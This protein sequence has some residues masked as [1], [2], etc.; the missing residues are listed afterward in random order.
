MEV[1][2]FGLGIGVA[3]LA[4]GVVGRS[5]ARR[6]GLDPDA[7]WRL[8]AGLMISGAIGGRLFYVLPNAGYYLKYPLEII[9]PPVEG[10]SYYGALLAGAAYARR[11]ARRAELT[12]GQVADLVALPWLVGLLLASLFWGAPTVKAGSPYGVRLGLDILYLTGLYALLAWAWNA[13]RLCGRGKLALAVLA[14]DSLL[15]LVTGLVFSAFLPPVI[16]WP[17][18][19]HLARA[20]A[21]LAGVAMLRRLR[22]VEPEPPAEPVKGPV[23]GSYSRWAG[24]LLVYGVLVL[25]RAAAA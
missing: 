19:D 2:G 14:G 9:R 10:L 13:R 12:F 15:R 18:L 20:A 3:C 6:R 16:P 8:V 17:V 4:G 23:K 25:I 5:L 21:V 11:F 24:W 22:E 1:H 7:W